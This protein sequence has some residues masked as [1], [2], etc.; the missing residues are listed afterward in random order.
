[1]SFV[2]RMIV[3][4]M[5]LLYCIGEDGICFI[6]RLSSADVCIYFFNFECLK[7]RVPFG[8]HIIRTIFEFHTLVP[9]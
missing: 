5:L 1:M 4:L 7:C 2:A 8:S 6:L 3:V 9:T